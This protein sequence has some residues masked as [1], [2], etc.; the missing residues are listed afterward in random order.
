MNLASIFLLLLWNDLGV[1]RALSKDEKAT[2]FS[3]FIPRTEQIL[4]Q[5]KDDQVQDSLAQGSSQKRWQTGKKVP[6]VS[7]GVVPHRCS[8]DNLRLIFLAATMLFQIL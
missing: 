7:Q 3:T 1:T 6:D 8:I 5:V 4:Q 2:F